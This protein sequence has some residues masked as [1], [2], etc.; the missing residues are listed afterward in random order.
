M[1]AQDGAVA[2]ERI[3]D[4]VRDMF[5]CKTMD[6]VADVLRRILACSDI[7]IVRFKDRFAHPSAGWRD[8]MINYR[9]KGSRHICEVQIIHEQL[10]V[11]RKQLG[12]HESYAQ[13]RNAREILEYLGVATQAGPPAAADASLNC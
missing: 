11:C 4:I 7:E 10:M 2:G 6:E 1:L 12:G 13:E 9:V 5:T 8:A 3:C